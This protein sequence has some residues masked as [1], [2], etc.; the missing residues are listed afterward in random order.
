MLLL[1]PTTSPSR[2]PFRLSLWFG[3]YPTCFSTSMCDT[4]GVK[5]CMWLAPAVSMPNL[6]L[7]SSKR[8]VRGRRNVPGSFIT[9]RHWPFGMENLCLHMLGFKMTWL[10][11]G[12]VI[13]GSQ[14]CKKSPQG[15][16]LPTWKQFYAAWVRGNEGGWSVL[17]SWEPPFS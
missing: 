12:N 6:P 5:A 7:L 10:G 4:E 1:P 2:S 17:E 14:N 13:P 9:F 8:R 15:S 16:H 11:L 3:R